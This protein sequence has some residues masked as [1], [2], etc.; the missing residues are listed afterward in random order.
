MEW[1]EVPAVHRNGIILGYA[2]RY[3]ST[4]GS[5]R[6]SRYKLKETA[7]RNEVV[8][9]LTDNATYGF[10]V[11]ARTKVGLGVFSRRCE[12]LIVAPS[13]VVCIAICKQL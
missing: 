3:Y 11:A 10:E 7:N 12:I 1:L 5:F 4:L 2:V 13:K 9:E 8:S 6:L